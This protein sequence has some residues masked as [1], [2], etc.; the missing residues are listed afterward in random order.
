MN[1]L[2]AGLDVSTQS[3]KLII[4]DRNGSD[5]VVFVHS[6]LYDTDLPHYMTKN[7]VIQGLQEGVAE[8]DP[9]MWLEAV[10]MVFTN[11]KMANIPVDAIRCISVSGQQHGLVSIDEK[12]DLTRSRSKLW[13][14][15]STLEECEILTERIGGIEAMIEEV[16]NSQRTGYTAAKIL[17]LV[18]D[19][20]CPGH[21]TGRYIGDGIVESKDTGLVEKSD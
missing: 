12:G 17:N 6:V 13:N 2:F 14:D 1:Q 20:R 8:S 3:C 21:G 5:D 16:G 11:L 7:G 9:K 4:I 15:F 10:D 18:F 19:G